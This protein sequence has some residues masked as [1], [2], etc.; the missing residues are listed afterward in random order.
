MR[1]IDRGDG[2][3]GHFCI[4]RKV[5]GGRYGIPFSEFWNDNIKGWCSAGSVY[6]GKESA[7]KKIQELKKMENEL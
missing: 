7:E 6:I 1:I 5:E 3:R 4:G 2:V